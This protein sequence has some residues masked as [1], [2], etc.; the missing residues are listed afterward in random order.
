MC[1]AGRME[2]NLV[3]RDPCRTFL[4]GRCTGF[5]LLL[6]VHKVVAVHGK[7]ATDVVDGELLEVG[8]GEVGLLE[9]VGRVGAEHS[10]GLHGAVV[11]GGDHDGGAGEGDALLWGPRDL[12]RGRE[13]LAGAGVHVV[14]GRDEGVEHLA[15]LHPVQRIAR[16]FPRHVAHDGNGDPNLV[17]P[18]EPLLDP[19]EG[20]RD[21]LE[22][23][24]EEL[25]QPEAHPPGVGKVPRPVKHL[26][27]GPLRAALVNEGPLDLG[28]LE[29]L[30]L[31]QL[32]PRLPLKLLR[33]RDHTIPREYETVRF[34]R[35]NAA[36]PY[37]GRPLHLQALVQLLHV[38]PD[39]AGET[40]VH[41]ASVPI[42]CTHR[43]PHV[44]VRVSRRP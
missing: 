22:L 32:L 41:K 21:V 31:R 25:V 24:R 5:L 38:E 11:G 30:L 43:G 28:P 20:L 34:V 19:G 10:D 2:H 1:T 9:L 14:L 15:Q 4:H 27:D 33:V 7:E 13:Q 18:L 37:S 23:L 40:K 42:L 26:R 29:A 44:G 3:V 17:H 39:V 6:Q 12:D 8:A 36:V 16:G 35:G